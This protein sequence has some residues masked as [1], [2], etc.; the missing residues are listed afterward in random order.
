VRS[1][2]AKT[3]FN[4]IES[5]LERAVD[6]LFNQLNT[7]ARN[8]TPIRTGRAKRGWR[9]TSTYRIGDSKVLVENKVPYI[10]L[11]DQGRSRQAPAGIIVPVLSKILKQRRTIR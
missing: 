7:D 8:I 6:Q 5:K 9:K 4:H 1:T 3:I 11:L 2:N 10:G